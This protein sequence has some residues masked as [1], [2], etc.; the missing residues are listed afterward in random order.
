[1]SDDY[2]FSYVARRPPTPKKGKTPEAKVTAACDAYLKLIGALVIRT[3]AGAWADENGNVI[4]G[5]KAGTSDKT[6]LLPGGRFI[7]LELKAGKNTL[8]EAQKRYKARVVA[9]GGLF[10]EAHGKDELRAAL[11]E[12]FGAQTVADWETLGRAKQK[13][14]A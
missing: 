9:L 8:S 10:I 6:V 3:N 14:G 4:M 2:Q 11:I 13:K 12:A 7:A 5:A 1:M